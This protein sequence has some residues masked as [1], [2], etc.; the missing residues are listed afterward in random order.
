MDKD[1]TYIIDLCDDILQVTAERNHPF[2]FLLGDANAKGVRAPMRVDAWYPTL[3]L[4][5]EYLE[6]QH[7]KPVKFMDERITLSGTRGQQRQI[8]DNRRRLVLKA[9]DINLIEIDYSMFDV[10]AHNRLLR[11]EADRAI[12][13]KRLR[14]G[15]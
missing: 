4:V 12:I 11:T 6:V 2:P 1:E 8:Y 15:Q 13:A 5:I 14:L 3:N 7:F 9:Y 10:D